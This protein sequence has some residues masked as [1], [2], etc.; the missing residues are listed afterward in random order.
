MSIGKITMNELS[1]SLRTYLENLDT[2]TVE[3]NSLVISEAI[4]D[5]DDKN[6][7]LNKVIKDNGDI[8][9]ICPAGKTISSVT[10]NWEINKTTD[11]TSASIAIKQKPNSAYTTLVY[12]NDAIE[13]ISSGNYTISNVALTNNTT[14]KIIVTYNSNGVSKNFTKNLVLYFSNPLLYGKVKYT[15][16]DNQGNDINFVNY[17]EN[18]KNDK[19]HGTNSFD[20]INSAYVYWTNLNMTFNINCSEEEYITFM[21]PITDVNFFING[22]N[23]GINRAGEWNFTHNRPWQQNDSGTK[24]FIYKSNQPCLGNCEVTIK[25]VNTTSTTSDD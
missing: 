9:Y 11:I 24:F 10:L 7:C 23:G 21:L 4:D 12:G 22:L 6:D 14:I 19:D 8:L 5:T 20:N 25:R 16:K 2:S 13:V 17:I 18:H 1:D 3:M 15:G